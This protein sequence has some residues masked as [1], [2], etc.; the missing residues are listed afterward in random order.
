MAPS[1]NATGAPD[2]SIASVTT[3]T[4][5]PCWVGVIAISFGELCA[6]RGCLD[7]RGV[8]PGRKPERRFAS[9]HEERDVDD[10]L[11][12]EEAKPDRHRSIRNPKP[13]APHRVR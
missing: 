4:I 9:G 11:Q 12:R 2:S 10:V 5:R 1:P 3:G 7:G 6:S 8:V 13:R